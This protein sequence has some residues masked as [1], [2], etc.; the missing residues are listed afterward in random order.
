VHEDW[1]RL[2]GTYLETRSANDM[3]M[4]VLDCR[5]PPTSLDLQMR[6][7]LLAHDRDYSVVLNKAD[8]LGKSALAK[9]IVSANSEMAGAPVIACSARTGMGRVE[10]WRLI[11]E[12][13]KLE[14]FPPVVA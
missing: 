3:V 14:K 10:L 1:D 7:W 12:F 2:V 6:D 5:L 9:A 13:L 11:S 4:M 8:K